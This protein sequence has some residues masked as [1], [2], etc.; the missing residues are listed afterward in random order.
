MPNRLPQ[1]ACAVLLLAL[2]SCATAGARRSARIELALTGVDTLRTTTVQP[3]VRHMFAW[4]RRGPWAIHVLEVRNPCRPAWAA[5]KAGPPLTER[6]T[7]RML[8]QRAVAA[9][10][11]DFFAIPLGTPT[12]AQVSNGVVLI[13]PGDRPVLGLDERG[14]WVGRASLTAELKGVGAMMRIAQVNRVR[15]DSTTND[16][17]MFTYWF[18][19]TAPRDT[20]MYALS[21]RVTR[22]GA[23]KI[24][25][26]DSTGSALP[27]DSAHVVFHLPR[28]VTI[29]SGGTVQ[30]TATVLSA[31]DARRSAQESLGGFPLLLRNGQSVL[32]EQPGVRPDFG[33]RRHPRSAIGFT[34]DATLLVVVDG[35]QAP[36]SDGMT[37]AEL[38]D[39]MQRLGAREALNFDGGGSTALVVQGAMVN[40]PSDQS[41][42]R[43]VG[44]ALVLDRCD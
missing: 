38:A 4:D 22:A 15:N 1:V 11:A 41:G 28:T 39:L 44:N 36:Y 34:S 26:I 8:G 35:R 14:F 40:R 29:G 31:E 24:E 21:V 30:W 42:E 19:S 18:G 10:N 7:P 37:L 9:I 25:R 33:E 16:V 5:R 17:R 3:G 6:A 2:S 27:L 12:G 20:T 23:G 32:A 43:P 13:G